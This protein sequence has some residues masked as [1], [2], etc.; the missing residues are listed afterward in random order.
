MIRTSVI[1]SSRFFCV[2]LI[3][4]HTPDAYIIDKQLRTF[5]KRYAEL[6]GHIGTA[7]KLQEDEIGEKGGSKSAETQFVKVYSI[8]WMWLAPGIIES[9][10]IG[11]N[12]CYPFVYLEGSTE[13]SEPI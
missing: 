13:Y 2:A 12:K 5:R 6:R 11:T 8:A 9:D 4:F 10:L 3:V 1:Y 7:A